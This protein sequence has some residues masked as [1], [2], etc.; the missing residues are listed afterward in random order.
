[1]TQTL[2]KA[3][4]ARRIELGM[5]QEDLANRVEGGMRQ[6]QVSR[7][8]IGMVTLPRH[9]RLECI[10]RA[11]GLPVGELLENAGWTGANDAFAA[12][13]TSPGASQQEYPSSSRAQP[14][15]Q[16]AARLRWG[17]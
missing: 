7:L 15:P 8:E 12:Q 17:D 6:A 2:G 14:G 3:I 16:T 4:R 5:T 9:D 10:A 1:M 11:L 13:V